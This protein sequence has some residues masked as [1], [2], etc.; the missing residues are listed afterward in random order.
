[1]RTIAVNSI[2]GGTGKSTLTVILINA[3]TGMG[4]RCLALDADASNNSLS[5]YFDDSTSTE[6]VQG[7]SIFDLFMGVNV[8]N[9]IIRINDR[10]DLIRGMSGST[11]SAVPTA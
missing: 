3:L 9:C 10:L 5:F 6:P 2:K 8:Q 4:C 11:S 1:M 7:K